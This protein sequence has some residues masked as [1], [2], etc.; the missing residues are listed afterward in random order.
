[1]K[2]ILSVLLAVMMLTAVLAVC[3]SAYEGRTNLGEIPILENAIGQIRM[4]G[5]RDDLY[6]NCNPIEINHYRLSEKGNAALE[7]HAGILAGTKSDSLDPKDPTSMYGSTVGDVSNTIS[8]MN[9]AIVNTPEIATGTAWVVYDGEY[10]WVFA[11]VTD[12]DLNSPVGGVANAGDGWKSDSL[13]IRI[14]WKNSNVVSDVYNATVNYEGY[15]YGG[16]KNATGIG[17]IDDGQ[18][19]PCSW[20][21]AYAKKTATGYNVEFRIDMKAHEAE[22]DE[23]TTGVIG[24]NFAI[25]D[26]KGD[27][28]T[29]TRVMIS[30]EENGGGDWFPA[31]YSNMTFNY[32]KQPAT[33]DM[34]LLYVAIAMVSALAIG[35]MTI[36]VLKRR[37]SAK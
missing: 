18:A 7:K 26:C 36:V 11:E 12:N 2:K 1:M 14:N 16:K 25:N 27:L 33:G 19:N 31:T 9:G 22:L 5:E 13:E 35:A 32:A 4:D 28:D 10:L 15:L 8:D 21:E 29:S 6:A 30:A 20:L 23:N 17:A 37:A 24:I 34:T 3:A